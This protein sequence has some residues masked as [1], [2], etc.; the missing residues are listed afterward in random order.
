MASTALSELRLP[1]SASSASS[2]TVEWLSVAE[3]ARRLA[4]DRSR[5]YALLRSGDLQATPDTLA[6]LQIDAAS[7]ER[8]LMHGDVAGSPLSPANA[9]LLIALA[10][11]DPLFEAH[12]S[13]LARLSR[14]YSVVSR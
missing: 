1:V 5:V 2:T 9:W 12:V 7:V 10:S 14:A 13:G 6:G 8:R 4:L 3:A 11:A